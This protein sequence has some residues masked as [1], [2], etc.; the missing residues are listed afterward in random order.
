MGVSFEK[1]T[2]ESCQGYNTPAQSSF[3]DA[4]KAQ[5]MTGAIK[6]AIKILGEACPPLGGL[7][8]KNFKATVPSLKAPP[9]QLADPGMFVIKLNCYEGFF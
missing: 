1:S 3:L 8:R 4:T 7:R 5:P 9:P 6:S 2:T